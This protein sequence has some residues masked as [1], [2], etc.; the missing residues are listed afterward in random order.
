MEGNKDCRL[1]INPVIC[2]MISVPNYLFMALGGKENSFEV[3]S[4]WIGGRTR[5]VLMLK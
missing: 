4:L 3:S 1:K 2:S 5:R